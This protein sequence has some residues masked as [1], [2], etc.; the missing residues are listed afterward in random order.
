MSKPLAILTI[1]QDIFASE[2][3][4]IV[5]SSVNRAKQCRLNAAVTP[6]SL[7]TLK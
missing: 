7:T 3:A 2:I 6:Q 4:H 1:F 5:C